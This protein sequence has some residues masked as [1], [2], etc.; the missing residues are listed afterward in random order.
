MT[1]LS[2][3]GRLIILRSMLVF[4]LGAITGGIYD[5]FS[6]EGIF[7]EISTPQESVQQTLTLEDVKKLFDSGRVV[8]IDARSSIEY[9]LGHIPGALNLPIAD[10][11]KKHEEILGGISKKTKLIIYCSGQQCQSSVKLQELIV[12]K[13]GFV[14]AQAFYGSWQAWQ[15]VGYPVV[16][17]G[18]PK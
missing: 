18:P 6:D 13:A 10:F 8:F 2:T 3:S 11:D 5:V 7:W 16:K 15:S 4:F 14:D 9:S 12:S 17:G 1:K